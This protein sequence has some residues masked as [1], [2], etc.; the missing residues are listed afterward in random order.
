[1]RGYSAF[2]SNATGTADKT[3]L[4][5][6]A[7]TTVRPSIMEVIVGCSATP[8]DQAANL[9]LARFTAAG[10]SAGSPPTP[11]PFDPSDVAALATCG[12]AHSAEPTY[13]AGESLLSISMNQR[14][15]FR[16]VAIPGYELRCPA[17]A[18]NGIGGK[19]ETATASTVYD[20]TISWWE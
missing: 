10:T 4:T 5:V 12:H 9:A 8:A 20:F 17:S 6:I 15:T 13:T 14:A 3:A 2:G 1:M 19:L 16:W 11:R 18:A 7:A